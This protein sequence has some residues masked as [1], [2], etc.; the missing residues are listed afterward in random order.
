MYS[1]EAGNGIKTQGQGFLKKILVP[2]LNDD[3]SESGREEEKE[4]VVQTGSYSYPSPDGEI[5]TITY[6]ADENGFQPTGDH[7]PTP[8]AIPDQILSSLQQQSSAL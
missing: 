3:G 2:V 4:I 6:V 5:I 8:P 7:I 1:Y